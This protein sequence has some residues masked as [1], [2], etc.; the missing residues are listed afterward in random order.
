MYRFFSTLDRRWVFLS[1]LLAV[2]VPLLADVR[3]PETVSPMVRDTFAVMEDL[4]SGS[5]ILMV[6][7]Y[8]PA[9][10]AELH[11]MA[12]AFTRHAAL[13]G[14]K[15]YYLTLWPTGGPMIA[16]TLRILEHEF[17]KYRYGRDYI[18]LGFRAGQEGVIQKIVL[19]L[20]DSY[21]QDVR[22]RVLDD[23]PMTRNI[24]NI[25]AMQLIVSV[26]AGTP[27][28]KEWVQYAG[29]PF[30]IPVV[31]GTTGVQFPLF[32]PYVPTP[33]RGILG[34]IKGAAE[35]EKLLVQRYPQLAG[36][37]AAGEGQRRM[38]PQLVAHLLMI[39]LILAG[40]AIYFLGRSGGRDRWPA[41]S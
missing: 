24:R 27:G 7:D 38:G 37:A 4:P 39:A 19:S 1:M 35:Y 29:T 13:R 18:D 22:G 34:G 41:S 20:R 8:D 26:S 30:D 3:F 5:K 25:R 2:A 40:N 23:Y 10:S 21:R 11:P 28:T 15:L 32:L 31:A 17:P 14:H 12:A 33:L 6:L 9:G 16:D 36:T